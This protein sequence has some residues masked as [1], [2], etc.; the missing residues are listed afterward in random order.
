M[1]LVLRTL[2]LVALVLTGCE[3]EPAER[4]AFKNFLQSRIVDKTGV[5][6]P[7][8]NDETAKSFGPYASHYQIILDFN[9]HL[10]LSALERAG[11]LKSEVSNLAD[12]VAHRGELTAL[13]EAMP[14]IIAQCES[15]LATVNAAHAALQQPSDLKAVYDKAFD[16]IVTRPGTLLMQMLP[17]LDKNVNA[18]IALTAYI[19]DHSYDIT[20][21][22]MDATSSDT[23]I[24]IQVRELL[25][26]LH[27]HDTEIENL[28][29]QFQVLL[30]GT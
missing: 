16:R 29:R 9:S 11:R 26:T 24:G 22:G 15:R 17:L 12:L 1:K 7:L 28:K 21:D 20:I 19:A 18:M 13:H 30:T 3:D 5:H 27:Q 6:I 25:E 14:G 8:M 2:C 4:E 23:T 10:D